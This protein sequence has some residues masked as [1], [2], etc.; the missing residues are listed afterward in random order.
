MRGIDDRHHL[1]HAD[2]NEGG[3]QTGAQNLVPLQI[4]AHPR[5]RFPSM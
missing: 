2:D 4:A 1:L 5:R 3:R